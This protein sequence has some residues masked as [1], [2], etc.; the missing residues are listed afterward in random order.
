MGIV[1]RARVDDLPAMMHI[2]AR[3]LDHMSS[4]CRASM[5]SIMSAGA[6]LV[7][8]RDGRIVGYTVA[9]GCATTAAACSRRIGTYAEHAAAGDPVV[10]IAQIVVDPRWQKKGIGTRLLDSMIRLLRTLGH[11]DVYTATHL[12]VRPFF[13]HAG[14]REVP[15]EKLSRRLFRLI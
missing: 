15:S 14:F 1:R 6:A 4:W 5:L 2:Q 13:E 11:R 7:A 9:H 10:V 12:P 8:E 3:G